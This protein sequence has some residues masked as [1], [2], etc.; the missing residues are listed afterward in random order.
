MPTFRRDSIFGD[1]PRARLDREQRAVF[2]AKLRMQR[3][4]N[5]ITH[6]AEKVGLAMADMLGADGRLDPSIDTLAARTGCARSAVA[7]GLNRLEDFKFLTR[8]RRLV[9]NQAGGWRCSQTSNAYVLLVPVCES[10]FR[11]EVGKKS[12]NTTPKTA[13]G[14]DPATLSA[15]HAEFEGG[16]DLLAA[17]RRDI[18]GRQR[19]AMTG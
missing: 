14:T 2:K 13:R 17:R 16:P 15:F 19:A 8:Q 10:G 3:R 18:E 6:T 1:G 7:D 12:Y 5:R 9:R 11:R 4:R